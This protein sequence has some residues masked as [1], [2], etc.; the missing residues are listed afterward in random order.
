M[1]AV[2]SDVVHR[3][4]KDFL[5]IKRVPN[6]VKEVENIPFIKDLDVRF[7]EIID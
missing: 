2:I 4:E 7:Y 3:T 5:Y 6:K 1:N